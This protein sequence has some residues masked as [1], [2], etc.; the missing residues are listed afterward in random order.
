MAWALTHERHISC[1]R[2]PRLRRFPARRGSGRELHARTLDA[3][4]P[5]QRMNDWLKPGAGW[6]IVFMSWASV[7]STVLPL[8]G[9]I[10]GSASTLV[11]QYLAL[12][13]GARRD[14][15]RQ[16]AEQRA[17]RKEAIVGFLSAAERVEHQRGQLAVQDRRDLEQLSELMHAVWLAKKIIELVCSGELAQAAHDYTRELNSGS[18]EFAR[19]GGSGGLSVRERKLRA[20][21]MEAARQEL[22]YAGEPLRHRAYAE[23]QR[24]DVT[25]TPVR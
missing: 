5:L 19:S 8:A 17:E 18:K 3:A 22:G 23:Q 16:A 6:I 24:H 21:F 9:V 20:D 7:S 12:R 10:L 13:G 2:Q 11:G 4:D 25:A 14:A 1:G 15:A